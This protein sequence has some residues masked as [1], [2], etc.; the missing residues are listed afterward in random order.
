MCIFNLW[1]TMNNPPLPFQF[2]MWYKFYTLL[3]SWLTLWMSYYP[4]FSLQNFCLEKLQLCL[5]KWLGL[6]RAPRDYFRTKKP[7]V[8]FLSIWISLIKQNKIK[9]TPSLGKVNHSEWEIIKV[10]EKQRNKYSF[11]R[12]IPYQEIFVSL[13]KR[14]NIN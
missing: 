14:I 7:N 8:D 9:H 12:I 11:K 5:S 3:L 13:R 10:R 4:F 1:E 2:I 6:L